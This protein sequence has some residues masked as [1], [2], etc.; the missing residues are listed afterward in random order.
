[1]SGNYET[2]HAESA[3]LRH[4][5]R[6][7]E[8]NLL[9]EQKYTPENSEGTSE[10]SINTVGL[11][12]KSALFLGVVVAF[13]VGVTYISTYHS[14]TS[15]N[16]KN[17]S[18]DS[19]SSSTS[20]SSPLRKG[21]KQGGASAGNPNFLFIVADDMGFGSVGYDTYDIPGATPFLNSMI[22]DGI[23]F[24]N[25][26][27]QEECTPS[28]ASLLTGRYPVTI[29]V[30]F[31][32]VQPAIPWGLNTTEILL[33]QVLNEYGNYKSY[34]VG[35][36]HLGHYSPDVLPTARGF[37][38]Y[39]GYMNGEIYYWTKRPIQLTSDYDML[40]MDK[41]CYYQYNE[42][43][44]NDYSTYLFEDKAKSIIENHDFDSNPMFLYLPYQTPHAP[45][46]D[47]NHSNG[48]SEDYFESGIYSQLIAEVAGTTRGEYALALYLMDQ[49]IQNVVEKLKEVG[50]FDNTYIIFASDNGGCF[51]SGGRNGNLRGC[52]GTMFE[53]GV[54]VDAFIYSSLLPDSVRGTNYTGLTHVSDW[55]PTIMDLAGIDYQPSSDHAFDGVSQA[56]AM[57]GLADEPRDSVLYNL[58]YNVEGM[59]F[60]LTT[61]ATFAIRNSRYKLIHAYVGN[62]MTKWYDF[63]EALDTDDELGSSTCTQSMSMEGTYMKM[64]YDLE[65]DPNEETN[66]YDYSI[67][68]PIKVRIYSQ[69]TEN[70]YIF[71]LI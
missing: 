69:I 4:P 68:N 34:G 66:L 17:N 24:T 30:Q 7:E 63:E 45:F 12:R 6:D 65:N 62:S 28:R 59:N 57:Q 18:K 29:G 9:D 27:A 26:Y 35:K 10:K 43:D 14:G 13:V 15:S 51:Q 56:L 53:G 23:M 55:F 32:I 1:M 47:K 42:D 38:Q 40:Y 21:K 58:Y 71:S 8:T 39:L 64:F 16:I 61:N 49:S 60:N 20:S 46:N 5:H 54:K 41:D 2:F 31:H 19:R 70:V 67:Y 22:K 44:L 25:Y 50:Q 36:W 3:H 37:D 11:I 52:K 48:L 33:P